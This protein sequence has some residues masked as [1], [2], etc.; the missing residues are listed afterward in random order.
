VSRTHQYGRCPKRILWKSRASVQTGA[1]CIVQAGLELAIFLLQPSECW[2]YRCVPPC[3]A[4]ACT[5]KRREKLEEICVLPL[6]RK[7]G[8]HI[9]EGDFS[10]HILCI[11]FD[12]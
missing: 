3:L 5:F 12:I 8:S 9:V 2:D 11:T 6:E 10:E 1:S 4:V 7:L